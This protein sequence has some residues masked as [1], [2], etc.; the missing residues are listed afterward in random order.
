MDAAT[1]RLVGRALWFIT[2]T[3]AVCVGLGALG[4]NIQELLHLENMDFML[5]ALVGLA[6][7]GSLVMFFMDC[8][9]GC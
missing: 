1:A 3:A 6:G 2:G 8:S 4:I 5:R 9:G 7:V